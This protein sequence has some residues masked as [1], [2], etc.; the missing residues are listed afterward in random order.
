MFY[1]WLYIRSKYSTLQSTRVYT[2]I[3]QFDVNDTSRE[4][5]NDS[6]LQNTRFVRL[7]EYGQKL[8]D[9]LS[10][11]KNI[12]PTQLQRYRHV[13]PFRFKTSLLFRYKKVMQRWLKL[14][15]RASILTSMSIELTRNQFSALLSYKIS[16][17]RMITICR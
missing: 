15:S 1:I 3:L 16:R 14:F 13:S 12:I 2:L 10:C 9:G 6:L 8:S 7:A 5:Q 4:S 17:L 11:I